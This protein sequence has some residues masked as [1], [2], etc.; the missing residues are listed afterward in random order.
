MF[1]SQEEIK[2]TTKVQQL[3]VEEPSEVKDVGHIK[4]GDH[5]QVV[6]ELRIE[7]LRL[8]TLEEQFPLA[9]ARGPPCSQLL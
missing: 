7:D 3:K 6:G 2:L 1:V 4:R 8:K 9:K 5:D